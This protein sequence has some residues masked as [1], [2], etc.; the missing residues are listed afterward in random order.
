MMIFLLIA[1][2]ILDDNIFDVVDVDRKLCLNWRKKISKVTGFLFFVLALNKNS[3]STDFKLSAV[4]LAWLCWLC[5]CHNLVRLNFIWWDIQLNFWTFL[6]TRRLMNM[7]IENG[8]SWLWELYCLYSY[9]WKRLIKKNLDH[10]NSWI[11]V[12]CDYVNCLLGF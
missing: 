1:N 2:L 6:E 4:F 7:I 10:Q 12:F 8:T 5:F 11:N 3:F 9:D